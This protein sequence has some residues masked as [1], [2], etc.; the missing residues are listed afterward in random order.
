MKTKE[1]T[2][3]IPVMLYFERLCKTVLYGI[4]SQKENLMSLFL[5]KNK[6]DQSKLPE[7]LEISKN[8]KS[9][10]GR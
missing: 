6:E 1:K 10:T 3:T 7:N 9:G 4:V 8:W 5:I 2:S